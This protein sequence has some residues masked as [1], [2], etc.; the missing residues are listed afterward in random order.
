M[1]SPVGTFAE[2]IILARNTLEQV[3]PDANGRVAIVP[4]LRGY[5]EKCSGLA[6]SIQKDPLVVEHTRGMIRRYTARAVIS[7]CPDLNLCWTRFVVCKELMHLLVDVK[8]DSFITD[9][10]RQLMQFVVANQMPSFDAQIASETYAFVAALEYMLPKNFRPVA[11]DDAQNSPRKIADRFKVPR[12]Y[13][14]AFYSPA[15]QKLMETVS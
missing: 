13:V 14:E 12:L 3:P 6:V 5:A 10:V 7:V 11:C 2:A 1:S 8:P 15:F 9:P 4:Q